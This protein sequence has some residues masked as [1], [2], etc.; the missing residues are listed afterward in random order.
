[1]GKGWCDIDPQRTRC[2]FWGCLRLCQFWWKS[3]KK[4]D[5]ESA[6]RRTDT[7]TLT[8]TDTN[9]FY[10]LSHAICYSYGTNENMTSD[11]MWT[12]ATR[13]AKHLQWPQWRNKKKQQQLLYVCTRAR[14]Y[15]ADVLYKCQDFA[16]PHPCWRIDALSSSLLGLLAITVL[17]RRIRRG[18]SERSLPLLNSPRT[19][20]WPPIL[21][22]PLTLTQYCARLMT[23][24]FYRA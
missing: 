13:L 15:I 1:M 2:Y 4:C 21:D 7:L 22:P 24:L 18:C 6:R 14:V 12:G 5:R 17:P 16:E 20:H 3:I 8:L 11:N 9:R 10:N 23:V 19:F